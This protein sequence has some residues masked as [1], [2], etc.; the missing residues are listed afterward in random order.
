GDFKDAVELA[1]KLARSQDVSNCFTNQWFRF[2]MG[3]MESPNDSC[4]IQGI[5][6][7]FRTSGGNVRELLSRIALSPAFRN[8]RLSGS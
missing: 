4:S 8:V 3:R 6:E 1:N 5:R 7:A 2:S